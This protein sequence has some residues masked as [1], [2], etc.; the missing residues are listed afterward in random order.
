MFL[1]EKVYLIFDR[2][3]A[4]YNQVSVPVFVNGRIMF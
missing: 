4:L 1:Q 3:S 2:D